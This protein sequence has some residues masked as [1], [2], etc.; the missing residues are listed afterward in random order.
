MEASYDPD[1]DAAYVRIRNR[2]GPVR[3]DVAEDGTIL[4]FDDETGEVIGY[5][6]LSVSSR[7]LD[8]FQTVPKRGRELVVK[9]MDVARVERRFTKVSDSL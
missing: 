6:L 3:T 9:A 5:E 8:A 2:I 4:D 1:A 7:G